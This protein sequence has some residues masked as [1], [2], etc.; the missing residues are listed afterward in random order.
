ML[1]KRPTIRFGMEIDHIQQE[2]EQRAHPKIAHII[3]DL[4][5]FGGTEVTLLRYLRNSNVRR[6]CQRVIVLK[7]IGVGSTVG[8][9]IVETGV[10]VVALDHRSFW[11]AILTLSR[12]VRELRAF[13]PDVISGWLYAPSLLTAMSA[14]QLS[15]RA[16]QVWHIRSLPF[17]TPLKKPMR[18][19]TQRMLAGLSRLIRPRLVLTPMPQ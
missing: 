4:N 14:P 2:N 13:E 3:G 5:G 15:R 12:L 9:Q 8:V 1:P 6:D 10:S 17:A 16:P 19:L 7:S 11:R 18:Y